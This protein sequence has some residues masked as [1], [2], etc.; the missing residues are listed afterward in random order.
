MP[1]VNMSKV[2]ISN[3]KI[4]KFPMSNVKIWSISYSGITDKNNDCLKYIYSIY[5][6]HRKTNV[7]RA[8]PHN[9][10]RSYMKFKGN[11]QVLYE[12]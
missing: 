1:N 9:K 6:T 5:W 3:V 11:F 12:I 10:V 2:T 4:S 8:D 7:H